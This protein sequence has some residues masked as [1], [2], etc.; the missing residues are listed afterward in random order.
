M[1]DTE[2]KTPSDGAMTA[3]R[4]AEIREHMQRWYDCNGEIDE[5]FDHITA[6]TAERDRL[7]RELD[8]AKQVADCCAQSQQD[9]DTRALAAE[10][11]AAELVAALREARG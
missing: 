5:I 9:A 1:T 3:E 7:A 11:R 8:V 4:L 2:R 6:L 10:A